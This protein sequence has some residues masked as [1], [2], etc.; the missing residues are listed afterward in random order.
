MS[1]ITNIIIFVVFLA[2]GTL[3]FILGWAAWHVSAANRRAADVLSVFAEAV[4]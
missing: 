3:I 4:S 2:V 1:S